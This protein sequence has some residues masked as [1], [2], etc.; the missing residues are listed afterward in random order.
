M[1]TNYTIKAAVNA[2]LESVT[3]SRS[4]NTART[5]HNGMTVFMSVLKAHGLNPETA[6][7]ELI[8]HRQIWGEDF[9]AGTEWDAGVTPPLWLAYPSGRW[10]LRRDAD[11]F[12]VFFHRFQDGRDTIL[13]MFPPTEQGELDAKACALAARETLRF[14]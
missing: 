6:M 4:P 14:S 12:V 5:Y 1:P 3:L 11:R 8:S 9:P 2:Y 13:G 10:T 7:T